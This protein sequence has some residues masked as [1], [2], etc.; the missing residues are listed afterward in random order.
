MADIEEIIDIYAQ[1]PTFHLD[2]KLI[3]DKMP[4]SL[5]KRAFNQLLNMRRDPVSL[6]EITEKS[7][8]VEQYLR[9][10]L[11][12]GKSYLYCSMD[13]GMQTENISFSDKAIQT[14]SL[15]KATQTEDIDFS[16]KL[17]QIKKANALLINAISI[18]S[19]I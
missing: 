3:I 7:D 4:P 6:E 5:V 13:T 14:G 16:A 8:R 12:E 10:K 2:Y 9:H 1:V 11:I 19:N 15:D 17:E 18:L